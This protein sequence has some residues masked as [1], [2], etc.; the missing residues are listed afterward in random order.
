MQIELGPL[1]GDLPAAFQR[2]TSAALR[3]KLRALS[4]TGRLLALG[5]IA[6]GEPIGLGVA[7]VG[8]GETATEILSLY[9]K[10]ALWGHGIGSRLLEGMEA[11]LRAR[12]CT[13]AALRYTTQ[14]ATTTA[15]EHMLAKRGW[16][17]PQ[18]QLVLA[19]MRPG[20]VADTNGRSAVAWSRRLRFSAGWS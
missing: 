12:G 15:L 11:A 1:F 19:Q 4:P 3:P 6:S 5:V 16:S 17:P 14:S 2:M 13:E 18:T 9:I 7:K 20:M 8:Q 10:P